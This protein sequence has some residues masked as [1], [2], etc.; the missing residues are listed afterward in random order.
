VAA[1]KKLN[2]AHATGALAVAAVVGGLTGSWIV[3]AVTAV[4]LVG[5]AIYSGDIRT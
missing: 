1:K 4:V 2:S 5:A 3:F